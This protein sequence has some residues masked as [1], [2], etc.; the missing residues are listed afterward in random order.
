MDNLNKYK[1][2]WVKLFE[3]ISQDQK[4]KALGIYRLLSNALEN[5]ALAF[6]IEGDIHLFFK[7]Y[8]NALNCYERSKD[9]YQ[10]YG[11]F[12]ELQ[13]IENLIKYIKD[14]LKNYE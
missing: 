6:K 7:D 11:Q 3:F 14:N 13:A 10:E 1:I 12:L 4:I 2:A 8:L 9:L 5:K